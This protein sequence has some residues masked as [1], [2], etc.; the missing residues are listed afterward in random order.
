MSGLSKKYVQVFFKEFGLD[1]GLNYLIDA[2]KFNKAVEHWGLK[3]LMSIPKDLDAES[4]T[5]QQN[6]IILKAAD[7]NFKFSDARLGKSVNSHTEKTNANF[8]LRYN[9][10]KPMCSYILHYRRFIELISRILE[11][12]EVKYAR[13]NWKKGG[14]TD[15]SYLDATIRHLTKFVNGEE[16]DEEYGTSHLGHAAWNLMT[17]FELND[18]EIMDT[19]KFNKALKLLKEAKSNDTQRKV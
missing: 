12:G 4:L 18:H 10:G 7:K 16:F 17:M 8:A 1:P 5:P 9:S 3:D 19:D 15:D 14:N 11:V 13:L 6:E 2:D